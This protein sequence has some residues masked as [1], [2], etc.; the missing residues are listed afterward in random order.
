MPGPTSYEDFLAGG[1]SDVSNQRLYETATTNTGDIGKYAQQLYDERTGDTQYEPT[2]NQGAVSDT[3]DTQQQQLYEQYTRTGASGGYSPTDADLQHWI[4]GDDPDKVAV[5]KYM[6]NERSMAASGGGMGGDFDFNTL[7]GLDGGSSS[8]YSKTGGDGATQFPDDDAMT[9]SPEYQQMQQ[10]IQLQKDMV[11]QQ[12]AQLEQSKSQYEQL[13]ADYEARD[14]ELSGMLEGMGATERADLEKQRTQ[15]MAAQKEELSRRGITSTSALSAALR[16]V[17]LA[18][19]ESLGKLEARLRQQTLDYRAQ[20]SGETLQAQERATNFSTAAAQANF[21]GGQNVAQGMQGLAEMMAAQ[22][23]AGWANQTEI[24]SSLINQQS[25]RFAA[26]L[27]YKA[28]IYGANLRERQHVRESDIARTQGY[29]QNRLGYASLAAQKEQA[30]IGA[31][32]TITA[33]D[34]SSGGSSG[35]HVRNPQRNRLSTEQTRGHGV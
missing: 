13:A 29:R 17:D 19:N 33:A 26:A 22:R 20:F 11:A 1:W 3:L 7:A 9:S 34:Y 12:Q 18:S 27:G 30:E 5:A 35:Y 10:M 2:A 4:Q 6:L 31:K 15:M 21:A 28:D 25:G 32:A 24:Q 14:S 16:G 8:T 23:T